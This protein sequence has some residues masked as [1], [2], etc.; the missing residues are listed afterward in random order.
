MLIVPPFS[1]DASQSDC[2]TRRAIVGRAILSPAEKQELTRLTTFFVPHI[3]D[4]AEA[5][6]HEKMLSVLSVHFFSDRRLPIGGITQE[7]A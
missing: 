4:V 5:A 3:L 6:L 1:Q 2:V 7:T